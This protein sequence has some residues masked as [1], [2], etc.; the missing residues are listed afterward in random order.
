MELLGIDNVF[1]QLRD[2]EKAI[3]FYERLGFQL[4]FRIPHLP[5]ALF[6][7][8]KEEPGLMLCKT[9]QPIPSRL[10]VELEN[11]KQMSE[12]CTSMEIQGNEVETKTGVTFEVKDDD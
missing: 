11:A 8:G 4:K 9:Q 7:I 5:G 12:H 6:H 2:L 10:W 1:F 3:P